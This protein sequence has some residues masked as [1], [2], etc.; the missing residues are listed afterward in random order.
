MNTVQMNIVHMIGRE[1]AVFKVRNLTLLLIAAAVWFAA[2]ANI[3]HIGLEEY[4]LGYVSALNIALS[5]VVGVVFWFMA[6]HKLTVKH[7]VRIAGYGEERQ[8]F[9]KFFDKRSFAIM[10]VMMTGGILI[11]SLHLLPDVFI[12]VFYTGL[13]AALALAGLLFAANFFRVRSGAYPADPI[14]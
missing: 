1:G 4:A 14:V 9:V 3:A 6:F 11:R 8:L 2:G 10:A 12:A 7:T 5:I 13:G